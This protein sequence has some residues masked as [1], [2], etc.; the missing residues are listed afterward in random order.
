MD[1][2]LTTFERACEL[3]EVPPAKWLQHLTPLLGQK[4]AAVLSQ[5]EGLQP[6]DYERV[7]QTLL[8]K[9]GLT[10][11]NKKRFQE[12]QKRPEETYVDAASHLRHYHQKWVFRMGA[13]S[14]KDLVELAVLERFYEM[15]SPDLRVWLMDWRPGDSH[16][17]GKLADDFTNSQAKVEGLY[18]FLV[19]PFGLKGAPATF[20]HLVNQRLKGMESFALAYMDDICIISQTWED[21][22]SQVKQVLD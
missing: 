2:F 12:A 9:F 8:H 18:E 3:H 22:V 14:L 10:P 19:L 21:H 5:L 1:E 7:K 4:A 13:Q 16:N 17:A 6:G 15:C 20:Q 11:E